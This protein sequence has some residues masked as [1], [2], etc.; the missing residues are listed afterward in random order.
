MKKILIFSLCVAHMLHSAEERPNR[1]GLPI[2]YARGNKFQ[3]ECFSHWLKKHN[4]PIEDRKVITF[5]CGTGEIELD[6]G[7]TA[8][9][10][11]GID[12]S[13]E[14]VEYA[15][16]NHCYRQKNLSFEHC[17]AEN[18]ASPT[19]YDLALASCCFHWFEDKPKAVKAIANSLKSGGLFFANIETSSNPKPFGIT[20][21]E[22]MKRDVPIIGTLLA[23]LPN[24]TGSSHP[25][26]GDLHVMLTEAGFTHIEP[27]IES[28][29]WTM[30]AQ[31]WRNAQLPLLLST[32]GAQ[33]LV[34]STS[35][36]WYAKKAS[37]GAFWW[38]N[39][40][41]EEKEEHDAPFFPESNH[42]LVQKIRKNNFCRYLF[43]KFLRG[44]LDKLQ[45][46]GDGTYT[47]NYQTTIIKATKK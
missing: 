39:M 34:N 27:K 40:S 25:D 14:M 23:M 9:S 42:E 36:N 29:D 46:N 18:F 44:C 4:V 3:I 21:F 12:A 15:Q 41:P 24:P 1:P 28:Y 26:Y 6:L 35:D 30:T 37:E 10:V 31:E 8:E 17:F 45:D 11:H 47:W 32:P 43:N 22:E 13:K 38:I 7:K 2:E 33:K 16:S 20:V 19:S 5:G